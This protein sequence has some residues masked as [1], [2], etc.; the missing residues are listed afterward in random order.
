VNITGA[1]VT[2]NN[3][4]V[5]SSTS[6]IAN[7]VLDPAAAVGPRTVTVTTAFG[8]SGGQT[9]TIGVSTGFVTF[10]FTGGDQTFTVPAGVVSVTIL[11]TGA[12]GAAGSG[13]AGGLG[14]RTTATVSVTPLASLT[15][16]VGGSGSPNGGFKE[17]REHGVGAAGGAL[18]A[19]VMAPPRS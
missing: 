14:G 1:G 12:G 17:A 9:F 2:V 5:G 10:N 11:A 18:R 19:C 6:L 3:V 4:V 8:T 7:L 15:V 16:R 13:A